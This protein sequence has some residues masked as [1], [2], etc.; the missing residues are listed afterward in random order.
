M[1]LEVDV[2]QQAL[3][4]I[5]L[6]FVNFI[7]IILFVVFVIGIIFV[8]MKM[9]R[10]SQYKITVFQRLNN[11]QLYIR[12]TT[13]GVFTDK[14][15]KR[16][17]LFIKGNRGAMNPDDIPIIP[18]TKG[19]KHILILQTG[20]KSYRYIKPSIE[21]LDLRIEVGEEDVNW[22]IQDYEKAKSSYW[23][24]TLLQYI[25]FIT[26][27]VVS[28]VVLV[29]FIY[30]VNKLDV[31]VD[32]ASSFSEAAKSFTNLQSGAVPLEGGA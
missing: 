29:M 30:L 17:Q 2:A 25:P 4:G 22:A 14:K 12:H 27:M 3:G 13:G 16:K 26:Q 11:N 20:D 9:G 23:E 10:Y 5:L 15:T 24:N 31:F 8:I 18:G 28:I 6:W 21:N 19:K 32:V 1:A 7:L